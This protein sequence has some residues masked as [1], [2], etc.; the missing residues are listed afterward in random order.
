MKKIDSIIQILQEELIIRN[1]SYF[2][3][4]QATKILKEKG[5]LSEFD[6]S[7]GYLKEKLEKGEIPQGWQTTDKPRQWRIQKDIRNIKTNH[8]KKNIN[9]NT[10][11]NTEKVSIRGEKKIK[12]QINTEQR[13]QGNRDSIFY[14]CPICGV[15][16]SVPKEYIYHNVFCCYHCHGTF[17]NPRYA[18]NDKIEHEKISVKTSENDYWSD[19]NKKYPNFKYVLYIAVI[20]LFLY[21]VGK[22][23][24]P[25]PEYD[26]FINTRAKMM[27]LKDKGLATE[28]DIKQYEDSYYESKR[29]K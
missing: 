2:A 26:K 19:Y 27:M 11:S 29:N 3:L 13:H 21:F 16:L 24:E 12:S 6:I 7:N 14:I 15:D 4:S 20:I 9:K 22:L 1:K 10:D 5:I 25:D 17:K 18:S 28:K 23:S 8:S